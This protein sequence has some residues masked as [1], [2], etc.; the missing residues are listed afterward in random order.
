MTIVK[1]EM[2]VYLEVNSIVYLYKYNSNTN[3]WPAVYVWVG[4]KVSLH[5]VEKVA[6]AKLKVTEKW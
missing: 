1:K 6:S 5:T 3:E 4:N 2:C